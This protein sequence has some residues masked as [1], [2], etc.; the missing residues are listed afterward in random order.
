MTRP[1]LPSRYPDP[2]SKTKAAAAVNPATHH[3]RKSPGWVV[4]S[5]DGADT[6]TCGVRTALGGI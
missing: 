6:E 3:C 1:L 2:R 4:L 5:L